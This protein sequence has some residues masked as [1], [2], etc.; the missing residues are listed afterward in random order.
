MGAS[1]DIPARAL[2]QR[3]LQILHVT[4]LKSWQLLKVLRLNQFCPLS[5]TGT[6]LD[7]HPCCSCCSAS[8]CNC[9]GTMIHLSI[10]GAPLN[11]RPC[12]SCVQCIPLQLHLESF[13]SLAPQSNPLSCVSRYKAHV[14]LLLAMELSMS[15]WRSCCS[16]APNHA[17]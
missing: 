16:A 14:P 3:T 6:P 9:F 13:H 10:T 11:K 7:K 17:V 5:I 1:V 4:T 8:P 2:T 15:I 12:C